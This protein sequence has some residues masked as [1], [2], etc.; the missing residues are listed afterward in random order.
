[1]ENNVK[2]KN[3]NFED[4]VNKIILTKQRSE[5]LYK[6]DLIK[7]FDKN[8]ENENKLNNNQFKGKVKGGEKEKEK[9]IIN[10]Y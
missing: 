2:E 7:I 9:G 6:F 1:L 8:F 10:I 5:N 4:E 3:D